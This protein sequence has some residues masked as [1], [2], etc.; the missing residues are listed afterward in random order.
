MG[1]A[2]AGRHALPV[3]P[4]RDRCPAARR[5][6]GA[7]GARWRRKLRERGSGLPPGE[8]GSPRSPRFPVRPISF[9]D[10][11]GSAGEEPEASEVRSR[12]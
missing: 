7:L 9:R 12:G 2:R 5:V 10:S 11:E 8:G 6:A 4:T 1:G 3:P